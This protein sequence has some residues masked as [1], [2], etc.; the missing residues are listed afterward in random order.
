MPLILPA[1]DDKF[2]VP[3]PKKKVVERQGDVTDK[4]A[5]KL[6]HERL[7]LN[8]GLTNWLDR[9]DRGHGKKIDNGNF[10]TPASYELR[11]IQAITIN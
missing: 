9:C 10:P 5:F 4:I 3:P 2:I 8:S 1:T 7:E 6:S 11:F